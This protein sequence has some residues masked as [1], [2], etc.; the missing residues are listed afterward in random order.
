M[1]AISAFSRDAGTSTR[2]CLAV[3]ALRIRVSM[4]AIGSVIK[5]R[6]SSPCHVPKRLGTRAPAPAPSLLP[7]ALRDARDVALE[8]QLA[9]AEAAQRELAHERAWAPAQLAA[10][11]QPNPVLRRFQFLGHLRGRCHSVFSDPYDA[12]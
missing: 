4:S 7:A 8:R 3:T 11:T 1:R 10:V 5:L 12:L 9:E 6:L 2:V